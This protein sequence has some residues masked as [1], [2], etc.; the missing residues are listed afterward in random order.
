MCFTLTVKIRSSGWSREATQELRAAPESLAVNSAQSF[1]A[2]TRPA[3]DRSSGGSDQKQLISPLSVRLKKG[4]L[5]FL[6]R[7]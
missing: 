3:A 6:R 1:Y 7:L 2:N 4:I 5:T